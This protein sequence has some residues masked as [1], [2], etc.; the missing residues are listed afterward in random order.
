MRS[1]PAEAIR[2]QLDTWRNGSREETAA[3]HR[4]ETL[5]ERLLKDDDALTAVL[6]RNPR[7]RHPAPARA[8]PRRPQGSRRQ[9]RPV[10]GP[11]TAAQTVPGPVPGPQE[12]FGLSRPDP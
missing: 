11:G 6:Q 5:R 8:D 12:P 9:R 10:A 1:A 2:A 7:R 3:M 4:L